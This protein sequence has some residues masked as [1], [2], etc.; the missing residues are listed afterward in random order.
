MKFAIRLSISVL[1]AVAL[2]WLVFRGTD[3]NEVWSAIRNVEIEWILASQFVVWTS[4]FVRAKRFGYILNAV[5]PTRYRTA[6]SIAQI[7][8]LFNVLLPM[9]LGD[10]VK[11]VAM[12][13]ITGHPLSKSFAAVILDRLM[14]VV[15]ILTVFIVAALSFPRDRN[16]TI[17]AGAFQNRDD[18]VISSK[19]IVPVSAATAVA[20][21]VVFG[22][23]FM[24]YFQHGAARSMVKR[25]MGNRLPRVQARVDGAIENFA[26][27]THLFRSPS[28]LG[29]A[30]VLSLAAWSLNLA[31]FAAFLNAFSLEYAWYAPF[32]IQAVVAAF[33]AA[34]LTPGLVGQLHVPIVASV[35][36]AVPAAGI[37]EA[38]ALAIVGHALSLVPITVLGVT[39]MFLERDKLFRRRT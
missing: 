31:S 7:G 18:I 29:K 17:P 25:L 39:C 27:G 8:F 19:L 32:V 33:L 23:L 11:G 5:E 20:V 16:A 36:M 13:R 9:R 4:H 38:K 12:T 1:I 28:G 22:V 10:A 34:P 15:G 21:V 24:I 26:A 14:E 37:A 30:L 35:L 2:T 3:W 6:L